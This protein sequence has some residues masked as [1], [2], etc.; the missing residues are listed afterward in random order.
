MADF[1]RLSALSVIL[2]W[3]F[4]WVL[5]FSKKRLP[6]SSPAFFS[7][8]IRL[9]GDQHESA[10]ERFYVERICT[11]GDDKIAIS[12][13]LAISELFGFLIERL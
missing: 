11:R 12:A 7:C 13:D 9:L 4:S 10:C 1:S 5:V 3:V 2:S 6:L 8:R